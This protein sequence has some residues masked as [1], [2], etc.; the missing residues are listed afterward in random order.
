MVSR[1]PPRIDLT[2]RHKRLSYHAARRVLEGIVDLERF[3][4]SFVRANGPL[5]WLLR[6]TSVLGQ[7]RALGSVPLQIR[8]KGK[9]AAVFLG[10]LPNSKIPI[11]LDTRLLRNRASLRAVARHEVAEVQ[12]ILRFEG[13][14]VSPADLQVLLEQADDLAYRME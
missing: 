8:T 1:G 11:R 5:G 14:L 6:P 7:Y 4:V 10:R 2:P 12:A 9:R 3:H 13:K